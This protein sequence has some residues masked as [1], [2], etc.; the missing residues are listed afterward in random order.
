MKIIGIIATIAISLILSPIWRGYVFSILWGW[1]IVPVFAL[2][3][4]T[5]V[6]S[7]GLGYVVSFVTWQ[8]VAGIDDKRS[9]N[10]KIIESVAY[11]FLMPLFAL[12]FGAVVN[13]FM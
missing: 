1:F 6:Q 2:Q 4:L 3:A 13:S 9:A 12:A 8:H 5:I 11:A 10:E 7:I